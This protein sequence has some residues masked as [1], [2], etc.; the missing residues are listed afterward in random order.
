MSD[1][2]PDNLPGPPVKYG[3]KVGIPES[4]LRLYR[5]RAA[6]KPRR[7]RGRAVLTLSLIV[8][9]AVVASALAYTHLIPDD[10]NTPEEAFLAMVEAI[11][12]R[13]AHA[14]VGCSVICLADDDL[15]ESET[16]DL[17]VYWSSQGSYS[18]VVHSHQILTGD[19]SEYVRGLLDEVVDHTESTFSVEVDDCCFILA[20]YT[21][22]SGGS[23][24]SNENPFPF[25]K[26]GARWYLAFPE[27][28]EG[29]TVIDLIH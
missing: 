28:P 8:V 2:D 24:Y 26:I 12:D 27:M 23:A 11:N 3:R 22:Y 10:G 15:R 25:V 7:G 14:L 4:E 20:N 5:P 1:R 18:I 16:T 9:V 6:E 29:Q 13:D 21:T 17:E 19:D